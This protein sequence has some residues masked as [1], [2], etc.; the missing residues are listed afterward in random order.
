MPSAADPP[1]LLVTKTDCHLCADARDVVARVSADTGVGWH[2][3]SIEEYPDLRRRFAEEIPVLMVDGVQRDFWQI[4][5]DRLRRLLSRR[6][7]GQR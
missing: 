3:K 5:E 4:D 6:R 2:E 1:L 7:S